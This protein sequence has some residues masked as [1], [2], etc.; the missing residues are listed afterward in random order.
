MKA[1]WYALVCDGNHV[2]LDGVKKRKMLVYA[3]ERLSD[4]V[5]GYFIGYIRLPCAEGQLPELR[6]RE[7]R[8]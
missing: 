2:W 3:G 4:I 7:A 6:K 5:N 1:Q 8:T